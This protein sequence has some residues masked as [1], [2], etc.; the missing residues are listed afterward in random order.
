MSQEE[1]FD[2]DERRMLAITAVNRLIADVEAKRLL[3]NKEL[4]EVIAACVR[5]STASQLKTLKWLLAQ[6]ELE[7]P[8][9]ERQRGFLN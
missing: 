1:A 2:S 7:R 5:E 6:Q 3:E 8:D 4:A 9:L